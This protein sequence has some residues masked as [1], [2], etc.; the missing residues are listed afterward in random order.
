M[1]VEVTRVSVRLV[2]LMHPCDQH[3]PARQPRRRVTT[4]HMAR[5]HEQ[6]SQQ[7]RLIT[8]G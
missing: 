4:A 6:L 2:H 5:S 8:C 3:A 7:K 1:H